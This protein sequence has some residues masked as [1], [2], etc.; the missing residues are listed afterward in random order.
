MRTALPGAA[1]N[2]TIRGKTVSAIDIRGV[3]D[4]EAGGMGVFPG[5]TGHF[6]LTEA[7]PE[8]TADGDLI[9]M[10]RDGKPLTLRVVGIGRP[11][12]GICRIYYGDQ[13]GKGRVG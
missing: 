10:T 6:V 2:I 5:A 8:G 3:Q 1:V 4:N 9:T 7:A 13:Y 11:Y 12:G